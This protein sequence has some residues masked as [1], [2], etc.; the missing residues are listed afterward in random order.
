M[1]MLRGIDVSHYQGSVNW[2][3][4]KTLYDIVWGAA[5]AGEGMSVKDTQFASNWHGMKAAG[6]VRMAYYYAHPGGDP[7]ASADYLLAIVRAQG[8]EA[9]DILVMDMESNPNNLSM[10]DLNNWLARWADHITKQ[11]GRKP[12]LYVGSGYISD[13]AT[14]DLTQHYAAWWYPRYPS[15]YARNTKWPAVITGYPWTNN[16][17]KPDIWQFSQSFNNQFDANIADMTLADLKT[18]G[19]TTKPPEPDMPLNDTDLSK[20]E[21]IVQRYSA[22]NA[23]NLRQR[24][25]DIANA[26]ARA[27]DTS[28]A[29]DFTG[30]QTAV[31]AAKAEIEAAIKAP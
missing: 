14:K 21:S 2:N 27:V 11:T 24:I 26:A 17:G 5:K 19:L 28:L 6:L 13:S 9:D 29:D 31:D 25:D 12:F 1:S 10:A 8:L 4:L 15:E 30:V 3:S 16:W 18:R 22:F 7:I 23:E 20:I